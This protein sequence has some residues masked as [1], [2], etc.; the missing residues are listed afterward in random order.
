[1]TFLR[2]E[3]WTGPYTNV[4]GPVHFDFVT[5]LIGIA[6]VSSRS[7]STTAYSAREAWY[8][9]L[10]QLRQR[11]LYVNEI[12]GFLFVTPLQTWV[13]LARH[14][15]RLLTDNLFP[16]FTVRLPGWFAQQFESLQIGHIEFDLAESLLSLAAILLTLPLVT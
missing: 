7:Q 15:E 1:M 6:F 3:K 5:V 8:Q 9:P 4:Y 12:V 10:A 13:K 14:G 16:A 11:R 2:T